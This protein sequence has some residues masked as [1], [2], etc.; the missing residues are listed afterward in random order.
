MSPKAAYFIS[1]PLKCINYFGLMDPTK[2]GTRMDFSHGPLSLIP[3]LKP[4]AYT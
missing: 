3:T 2:S 1:K 4:C